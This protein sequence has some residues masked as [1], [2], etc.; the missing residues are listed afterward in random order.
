MNTILYLICG[1][2][3]Q[4]L[5]DLIIDTFREEGMQCVA[6]SLLI[7]RVSSKKDFDQDYSP[8]EIL[9]WKSIYSFSFPL[10]KTHKFTCWPPLDQCELHCTL[11]GHCVTLLFWY[12]Y[13]YVYESSNFGVSNFCFM[14]SFFS[15]II[16]SYR[17]ISSSM[18]ILLCLYLYLS[19]LPLF[20]LSLCLSSSFTLILCIYLPV[21]LSFSVS[22]PLYVQ[23]SFFVSFCLCIYLSLY[24]C[25][26]IFPGNLSKKTGFVKK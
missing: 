16:F 17:S 25:I 21:Y 10:T 18:H 9:N 14:I 13:V 23:L 7:Y 24:L 15:I 19:F 4:I 26:I 22:F 5:L 1:C 6:F 2:Q 20:S 3:W 8:L 12:V 11:Y